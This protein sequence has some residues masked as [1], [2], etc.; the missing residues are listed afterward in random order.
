MAREDKKYKKDSN[1]SPSKTQVLS[2]GKGR[3]EKKG[4]KKKRGK[5]RK[6]KGEKKKRGKERERRGERKTKNLKTNSKL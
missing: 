6:G 3:E 2:F 4:E 5:E 1:P